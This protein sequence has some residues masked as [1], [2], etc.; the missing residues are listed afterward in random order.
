M[1]KKLLEDV[2]TVLYL[3]EWAIG[4]SICIAHL[5]NLTVQKSILIEVDVDR[6]LTSLM[7]QFFFHVTVL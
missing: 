1:T 6:S 3:F 5:D 2:E 4:S 7:M